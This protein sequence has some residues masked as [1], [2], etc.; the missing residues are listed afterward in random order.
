MRSSLYNKSNVFFQ[1]LNEMESVGK[2]SA[3]TLGIDKLR[4]LL[5]TSA[6]ESAFRKVV[7]ATMVRDRQHGPVIELNRISV[8]KQS[9]AA[10]PTGTGNN[11]G[12]KVVTAVPSTAGGC[13]P[14]FAQMV[15]KVHLLGP[16]SLLLPHR[17]WK[18]NKILNSQIGESSSEHN[19]LWLF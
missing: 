7:Q 11:P 3:E 8:R 15:G 5:V 1:G 12:G 16:E 2:C 13:K 18:V 17:V 10:A 9:A 19:R 6:K 14:V 4:T